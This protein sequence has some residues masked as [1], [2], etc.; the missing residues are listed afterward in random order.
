MASLPDDQRLHHALRAENLLLEARGD[1]Y[2]VTA[3]DI[4]Q[5]VERELRTLAQTLAGQTQTQSTSH[6]RAGDQV[7]AA[8][9]ATSDN[10][11][12][13]TLSNSRASETVTGQ[14]DPYDLAARRRRA[15]AALS[16]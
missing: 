5:V 9:Q 10:S 13:Q 3:D 8:G 7:A 12:V 11:R 4:A 14:A 16:E 2:S 15:L 6:S 1:R